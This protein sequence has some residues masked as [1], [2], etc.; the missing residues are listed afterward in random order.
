LPAGAALPFVAILTQSEKKH[1]LSKAEA[2]GEKDN[3]TDSLRRA[4]QTTFQKSA[5]REYTRL[6]SQNRTATAEAPKLKSD[7]TH[8]HGATKCR[9]TSKHQP[10]VSDRMPQY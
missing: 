7:A 2:V 8:N 9:S 5:D 4:D 1:M 10:F 6:L 3:D